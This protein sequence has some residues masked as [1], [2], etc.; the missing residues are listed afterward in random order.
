[1]KIKIRNTGYTNYPAYV[2]S[3]IVFICSIA[4]PGLVQATGDM[5]ENISQITHVESIENHPTIAI[6]GYD[7][8]AYFTQLKAAKGSEDF[9][10][11]WL[12]DKWFFVNEEHKALFITDS[13][14]YMP[15]YGG[16]C[17]YDPVSSGH[18]HDVDPT[19]WNIVNDKLYLYYSEEIAGQIL[20][21][22]DWA[23]VK[24]GLPQ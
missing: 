16:Y 10:H 5:V 12:G 19:V 18:G 3:F 21:V 13:M 23:Q 17:S 8:V 15:N 24:A 6:G 14:R 11:E 20:N 22:H 1:M 9:S 4:I 7:P 2:V